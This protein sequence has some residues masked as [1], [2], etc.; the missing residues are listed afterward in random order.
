L[1]ALEWNAESEEGKHTVI[2][3]QVYR[4][5]QLHIPVNRID[6]IDDPVTGGAK[7]HIRRE[8]AEGENVESIVAKTEVVSK[9]L[10]QCRISYS[11]IQRIA[12]IGHILQLRDLRLVCAAVIIYP[13]ISSP[14]RRIVKA[15]SWEEVSVRFLHQRVA[16]S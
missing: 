16:V 15:R 14:V 6:G 11:H 8:V 10:A 2:P 13:K 1:R 3:I 7:A 12:H 9:L 4:S 5:D